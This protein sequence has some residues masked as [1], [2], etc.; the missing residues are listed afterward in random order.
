MLSEA[1][2]Q[3]ESETLRPYASGLYRWFHQHPELAHH[4][5]ETNRK[6][7][8][9]LDRYGVSYL[10]PA[11]NITIAVVHGGRK[12]A[13][14]GLRCDTDA[15]PVREETGLPF[16]SETEGVMHACGH[17]AHITIGLCTAR[18]LQ[19]YREE[20]QG[21]VKIIFQPAEEG[22]GG[23][24]K[25]IA[26]GLVD[27]VDVFFAIHVWS[28]FASGT[29]HASPIIVSAAVNMFTIRIKGLGGHGATPEKCADAVAAG[30]AVVT[31]I[32]SIV[33]R[34]VSPM[35]PAVITI[36]SFHAGAAGNVVAEEAVL[37]G[38]ARALNEETREHLARQ[39]EAVAQHAAQIHG[40]TAAVENLRIC[41]A[42]Q[43]D[44][45]VTAL[46]LQCAKALV[47]VAQ[48]GE[49]RTM[50]LGDDFANYGKIAPYCYGQ[51]GIA[52]SEKKTGYAHHNGRFHV[53]EDALPVCVAWMASFAAA[54][55]AGWQPV[56]AGAVPENNTP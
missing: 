52:D 35:E 2:I 28:P 33:S 44:P 19:K 25:V 6:I 30:A 46:A 3:A 23:A 1:M 41:D 8:E 29:V 22:E 15:L 39:I 48:I 53:D 55:G 56:K 37:K 51:V 9:E 16:R 43:N 12:G 34:S 47:P 36:G 38:T 24:D 20:R 31:E 45:R 18:I 4:E 13:V 11:P 49:Q 14:V 50:M 26:T 40:C 32:Q 27:D 17:D 7:R 10:A 21:T 42:V 5:V 54:A